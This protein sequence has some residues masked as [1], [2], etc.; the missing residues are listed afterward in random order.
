MSEIPQTDKLQVSGLDDMSISW[1]INMRGDIDEWIN[2]LIRENQSGPDQEYK[3]L[4]QYNTHV[5]F[6]SAVSQR[7]EAGFEDLIL[8]V[9]PNTI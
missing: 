3:P 4:E 2:E 6:P 7:G 8:L 5:A 9:P 1:G